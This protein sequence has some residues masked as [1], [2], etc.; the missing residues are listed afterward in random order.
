MIIGDYP[1]SA[2]ESSKKIQISNENS[3]SFDACDCN[4]SE[5]FLFVYLC[6]CVMPF[7]AYLSL[8]QCNSLYIGSS[9]KVSSQ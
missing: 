5:L 2:Q 8:R 4:G 7:S 1:V 9:V 6:L 3:C